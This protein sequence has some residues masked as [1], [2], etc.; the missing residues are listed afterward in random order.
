MQV[1]KIDFN[2]LSMPKQ[3]DSNTQGQGFELLLQLLM[4]SQLNGEQQEFSGEILRE[5]NLAVHENNGFLL[6]ELPLEKMPIFPKEQVEAEVKGESLIIELQPEPENQSDKLIVEEV[7]PQQNMENEYHMKLDEPIQLAQEEVILQGAVQGTP[8]NS[9]SG[10]QNHNQGTRKDVAY[11]QGGN[12]NPLE[13]NEFPSSEHKGL[14]QVNNVQKPSSIEEISV[15]EPTQQRPNMQRNVQNT[16]MNIKLGEQV[17]GEQAKPLEFNHYR[18]E[19]TSPVKAA[20]EVQVN[21]YPQRIAEMVKSMMLQQNP[22]QTIINIKLLP[23]QLGEVNVKLSWSKGELTAHFITA[24]SMAKEAL[25]SA[26]PQLKQLLS[27]QDIRLSEAAVFMEQQTGQ[28]EQGN[29]QNNRWQYQ[30]P[31]RYKA[32]LFN[33]AQG[34]EGTSATHINNTEQGLN[35]VV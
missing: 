26:F 12:I 28:W 29:G 21:Q 25:E 7:P 15:Q 24:T 30:S 14:N 3:I 31:I 2:Q 33:D 27:Q 9:I 5:G 11:N 34:S 22:G 4:T 35:I 16:E 18:Q 1:N 6:D 23:Q 19:A 13:S 10:N 20:G 17:Q 32:G 8:A